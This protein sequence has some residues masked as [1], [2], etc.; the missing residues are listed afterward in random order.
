MHLNMPGNAIRPRHN[1]QSIHIIKA[2]GRKFGFHFRH[3]ETRDINGNM[4]GEFYI[5]KL[6]YATS[7]TNNCF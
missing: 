2:Y 6:M 3:A 5:E 1:P 4:I 7:Y